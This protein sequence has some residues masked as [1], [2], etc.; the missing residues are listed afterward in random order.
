M[1]TPPFA[2]TSGL[3]EPTGETAILMISPPRRD[4][5][6]LRYGKPYA[7]IAKLSPTTSGL[8]SRWRRGCARK[9]IPRRAL[10]H[11]VADGLALIEDFG[12]G[13]HR[14]R[15]RSRTRALRR[16]GRAARRSARPR[17]ARPIA[18]RRRAYTLPTYD[19]EAMLI[20]VELLSTGM[21]RMSRGRRRPLA[22][23]CNSW[24]LARGAGADP[25]SA[26]HLDACAISTRPTCTGWPIGMD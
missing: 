9:A 10:A 15:R 22:R 19:I 5:P 4:G 23:G 21:R 7:A 18:G 17:N 3:L 8:S 20:E 11:S 12:V 6:I 1:A 16:S 14:R 2:P 13:D 25:R 24:R 26:D